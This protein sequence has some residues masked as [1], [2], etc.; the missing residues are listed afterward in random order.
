[1]V[2]YFFFNTR[3]DINELTDLKGDHFHTA[4]YEINVIFYYSLVIEP[5]VQ[6]TSFDKEERKQAELNL[7]VTCDDFVFD[8]SQY[9]THNVVK[10]FGNPA[11]RLKKITD[12]VYEVYVDFE[13]KEID[14]S[15]AHEIEGAF[16][17]AATKANPNAVFHWVKYSATCIWA[18]YNDQYVAAHSKVTSFITPNNQKGIYNTRNQTVGFKGPKETVVHLKLTPAHYI[19]EAD[20]TQYKGYR[21]HEDSVDI[22][23]TVNKRTMTMKYR[24]GREEN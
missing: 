22:G 24:A 12:D 20:E 17:R 4:S 23:D 13:N 9:F 18:Y 7:A 2:H 6:Y 10:G 8:Y 14:G 3:V 5:E 1:M 15:N 11:C 16:I 21:I 19:S